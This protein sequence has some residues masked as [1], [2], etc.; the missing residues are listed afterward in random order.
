MLGC[1]LEP[2]ALPRSA[3]AASPASP[4]NVLTPTGSLPAGLAT[5]KKGTGSLA[6][7]LTKKASLVMPP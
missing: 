7:P 4:V 2:S 6:P 1:Q 5:Q 3:A